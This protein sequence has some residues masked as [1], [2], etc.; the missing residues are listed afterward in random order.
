MDFSTFK[1]EEKKTS[2][3]EFFPRY[4]YQDNSISQPV[5]AQKKDENWKLKTQKSPVDSPL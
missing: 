5:S 2:D 3:F 1:I 4:I